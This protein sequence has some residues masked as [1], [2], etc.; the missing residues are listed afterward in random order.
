VVKPLEAE[1]LLDALG[2]ALGT[3]VKFAGYPAGTRAGELAAAPQS[4]S[5][6]RNADTA[7]TRFL[8]AFGKPERLLTC[9]CERAA[10]PGVLQ[11][12]QLMTGGLAAEL[13]AEP[14]NRIGAML[15]DG[16]SDEAILAELYLAAVARP[17]TSGERDGLLK[18]VADA[19]DRR[20][21]WEDVAWGLVNS[22]GFLLRR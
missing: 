9:E 17:P 8:K 2:R 12:F 19:K 15:T 4:G 7:G 11:A 18:Y 3:P 22:K 20:A 1:Q 16:A 5:G 21:A 6:R 14:G 10:D 13:L